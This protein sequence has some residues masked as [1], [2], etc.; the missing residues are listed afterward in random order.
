MIGSRFCSEV[1]RNISMT[2][3]TK[4]VFTKYDANKDGVLDKKEA[5]HDVSGYFLPKK[6]SM[7]VTLVQ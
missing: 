5:K 4:A 7:P 3:C 2:Q 6:G 1:P